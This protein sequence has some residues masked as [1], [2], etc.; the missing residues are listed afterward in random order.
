MGMTAVRQDVAAYIEDRDGCP[1]NPDRIILSNGASAAICMVLNTILREPAEGFKDGCL[2][3]VPQYPLYSATLTAL[4]AEFVPYYLDESK[5]WSITVESLKR[6]VEEARK[7]NIVVRAIVVINPGMAYC[8]L[9]F[10]SVVMQQT[11]GAIG[12]MAL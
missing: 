10:Y 3:P 2:T 8:P 12:S 7:N 11:V 1:A 9:V 5:G 6:S 4:G